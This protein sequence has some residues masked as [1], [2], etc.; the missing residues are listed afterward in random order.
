MALIDTF[1]K[2]D[3]TGFCGSSSRKKIEISPS[4]HG[5]SESE[6]Q[7]FIAFSMNI[8]GREPIAM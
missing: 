6:P 7:Y 4:R 5:L 3:N 8:A 2:K 1:L